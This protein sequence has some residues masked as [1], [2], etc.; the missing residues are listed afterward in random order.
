MSGQKDN[1]LQRTLFTLSREVEFFTERELES[2]IGQPPQLWRLALAKELIDNALDACETNDLAPEITIVDTDECLEVIDNGPGLPSETIEASLNY[3]LRASDKL[4]WVSPTRGQLGNALKCAYAAAYVLFGKGIVEIEAL[5]VKHTITT[6]LDRIAQKPEIIREESKSLVKK[7]TCVRL[8]WPNSAT[9]IP[10]A[11]GDFL[12]EPDTGEARS[13]EDSR[14]YL[15]KQITLEELIDSYAALNPHATFHLGDRTWA[16][17]DTS[18]AKW[19]TDSPT[20]AHWYD[21][22]RLRDLIAAYVTRERTDGQRNMT[23]RELVSQFR[24]LSST[25]KQK[26]VTEG[27]KAVHLMDLVSGDD[28]DAATVSVLLSR[29]QENS[30]PVKPLD[31]GLIGE[32]HLKSWVEKHDGNLQTFKYVKWQKAK[33]EAGLPLAVEVA[34]SVKNGQ[35]GSRTWICGLNWAP[36]LGAPL[37]EMRDIVQQQRIDPHHPVIL[38]IHAIRPRFEFLDHAKS[39]IA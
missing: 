8:Y 36:M 6:S 24:G 30:R 11:D 14:L 21:A 15:S 10:K 17:S 7:G 1:R 20:S 4:F 26:K 18:W 37:P 5:G 38:I 25:I 12:Q 23:V 22:G 13:F 39:R 35:R 29:M 34:F 31:L 28:I 32:E 27:F 2:Q 9:Y 3:L 19:R 16:A 33:D